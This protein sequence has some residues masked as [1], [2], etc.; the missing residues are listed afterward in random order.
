M[1]ASAAAEVLA[2]VRFVVP[3]PVALIALVGSVAAVTVV[4]LVWRPPQAPSPTAPSA[5]DAATRL[6]R[7]RVI[8]GGVEGTLVAS[9]L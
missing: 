7:R 5:A 1:N 3:L 8:G 4:A 2:I 9:P 6:N